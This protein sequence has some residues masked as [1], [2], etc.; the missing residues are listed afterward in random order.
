MNLQRGRKNGCTCKISDLPLEGGNAN[1]LDRRRKHC[2]R[3]KAREHIRMSAAGGAGDTTT[4]AAGWRAGYAG[5][6]GR[7]HFVRLSDRTSHCPRGAT[8]GEREVDEKQ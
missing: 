2:K 8:T 3:L 7:R 6:L 1:I 4:R 5:A